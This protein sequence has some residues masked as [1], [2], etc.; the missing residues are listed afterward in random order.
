M[1][2]EK[3]KV[4]LQN[5]GGINNPRE[6]YSTQ[7]VGRLGKDSRMKETSSELVAYP[8]P[9]Y[10]NCFQPMSKTITNPDTRVEQKTLLSIPK[11]W[12]QFHPETHATH[13]RWWV[14]KA[15]QRPRKI[16]H[17]INTIT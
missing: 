4:H 17:I 11:Q 16:P 12:A 8:H 1:W 10:P 13:L 5:K 9:Q 3:A 2:V 14:G 15:R 7:D 6:T